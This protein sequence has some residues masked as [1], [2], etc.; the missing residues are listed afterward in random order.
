[1]AFYRY[2][3]QVE[4]DRITSAILI[5]NNLMPTINKTFRIDIDYLIEFELDIVWKDL[6]YL[7]DDDNEVLAAIHPKSKVILMNETKK[8]LFEEKIGTMNFSKAHELGHWV[9]HVTEEKD[10]EQLIFTD[11]D[12][13]YCRNRFRNN[14]IE[15]QANMFAASLLMPEIVI[16]EYINNL[17]SYKRISFGD[18]YNLKDKL[19]VSISALV[20]RI[21]DLRLLHITTGGTIYHNI[22]EMSGQLKLF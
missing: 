20:R 1:M 12:R 2:I 15:I 11:N 16:E 13:F 21:N 9:L 14:P 4:M 5:N 19:E 10:Y 22:D 8:S 7:S 6:D 18:L 3:T 17:K